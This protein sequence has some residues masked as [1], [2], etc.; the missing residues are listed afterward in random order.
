VIEL[1]PSMALR[2]FNE[3]SLLI[4]CDTETTLRLDGHHIAVEAASVF[5]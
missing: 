3:S 2:V 5:G 1:N 4:P